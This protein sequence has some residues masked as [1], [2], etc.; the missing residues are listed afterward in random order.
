MY[1]SKYDD[2]KGSK[3]KEERENIN[4]DKQEDK[5][6]FAPSLTSTKGDKTRD[7]SPKLNGEDK[8]ERAFKPTL[9]DPKETKNDSFKPK[10]NSNTNKEDKNFTPSLETPE[11]Q[12]RSFK[13]EL[14]IH[15]DP[16]ESLNSI[17][18]LSPK[19]REYFDHAKN[20][21]KD[22]VPNFYPNR[23][24]RITN[25]FTNWIKENENDPI[26]VKDILNQAEHINCL[27]YTS[28]SPRD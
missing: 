16:E 15:L 24:T 14:N 26:K 19:F 28:P 18:K 17:S 2:D 20:L 9:E 4:N 10:L 1:E 25:K 11:K 27:L 21:G 5:E 13:P 6:K 8:K 12:E 23:G 22:K 3:E 7:F